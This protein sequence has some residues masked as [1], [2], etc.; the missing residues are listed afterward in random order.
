MLAWARGLGVGGDELDALFP[1][2]STV[3]EASERWPEELPAPVGGAQARS[4]DDPPLPDGPR[5]E[6]SHQRTP[7]LYNAIAKA[8][9]AGYK[10]SQLA[11]LF[12]YSVGGMSTLLKR[13][14][15]VERVETQAEALGAGITRALAQVVLHLDLM[16]KHE[17]AIALPDVYGEE[18]PEGSKLRFTDRP[19]VEARTRLMDRVLPKMPT[20]GVPAEAAKD[21]AYATIIQS[22]APVIKRLA[23]QATQRIVD[24]EQSP[25]V[26]EGR[27]AVPR[28]IE[29]GDAEK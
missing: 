28:A 15:M 18:L 13:P 17:L 14:E 24:I 8:A 3:D 16:T 25:F 21:E 26:H 7:A 27:D 22:V 2:G 12:G 1:V 6:V 23:E 10:T 29:L 20:L 9:A 5:Y 19:S 4:E 11:T